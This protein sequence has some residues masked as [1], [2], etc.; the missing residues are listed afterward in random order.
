MIEQDVRFTAYSRT[1]AIVFAVIL[2]ILSFLIIRPFL[3]AILSAAALSYIFYPVYKRV[4]NSLPD[5]WPKEVVA[6]GLTCLLIMVIVM[7]PVIIIALTLASEVRSGYFFLQQLL[8]SP[9]F[10]FDLPPQF[11]QNLGD[12]SQFKGPIA[13]ISGSVI[14][15]LEGILRAIPNLVLNIFITIF[16]TYYFLKHAGEIYKYLQEMLPLPAGKYKQIVARFDDLS[17]GVIMG[18]VVVG[19]LQGALAGIGFIVIGLPNPVLWGFLTAIISIIPLLGAALVWFPI[20]IYLLIK[21]LYLGGLWKAIFLLIYG[22]FVVSL[23]DNILKPKIVGEHANIHPL[24]VLFGILGGIQLFGLPG[25]L[26]GPLILT[27]F[28]LI[29]EIYRDTL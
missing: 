5:N 18:Q 17:R 24:I 8:A 27:I 1:V 6:S 26:I 3:V 10:T 29:I 14:D 21:G 11:T 12:L 25:I 15:W 13:D 9:N 19:T 4:Q 23:I 20:F 16:S 2:L 7:I 22:T 28:D